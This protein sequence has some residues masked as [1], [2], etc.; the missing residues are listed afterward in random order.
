MIYVH[1]GKTYLV[2]E[3]NMND[4]IAI[5]RPVKNCGYFTS[6]RDHTDIIVM[7]KTYSKK[8]ALRNKCKLDTTSNSDTKLDT[9][10]NDLHQKE[11]I[12]INCGR[13]RVV[14]KVYGYRK[15]RKISGEIFDIVN[16][17]GFP[18]VHFESIG[19]WIDLPISIYNKVEEKNL[20]WVGGIHAAQHLLRQCVFDAVGGQS[21]DVM[22][23]C[24]SPHQERQRPLR[25]IVVDKTPGGCGVCEAAILKMPS[26]LSRALAIIN[27]CPC[28]NNNCDDT[29]S[30][31]TNEV[32]SV[33]GCPACVMDPSCPERNIA[34]CKRAAKIIFEAIQ[35]KSL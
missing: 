6:N 19:I 12:Q 33:R 23:E 14:T 35:L 1:Q 25:L 31:T 20:S 13:V 18:P 5:V 10:S 24:A 11:H 9:T 29:C 8:I 27:Q 26:I 30:H 32:Q 15:H 2:E 28:D 7:K 22:T 17:P 34:L 4:M 16:V 3:L 21:A